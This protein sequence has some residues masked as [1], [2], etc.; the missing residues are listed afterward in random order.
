MNTAEKKLKIGVIGCGNIVKYAHMPAFL[1]MTDEAEVVALCD[2]KRERAEFY[3]RQCG[4]K[5]VFEDYGDLIALPEIDAVDICLPNYLHA[6][7][8]C[9]AFEAGKHVFCEKP[10]SISVRGVEDMKAAADKAGRVLMVMR[11][12]RFVPSS[13]YAKR[14]I[15]QG[16][17]GQIYAGHC[18]WQRRRGIPGLGG[19][20]TTKEMSGGGPLIDLGVHMIDLAVYL[21]GSPRP[22][23]VT[24]VT[25]RKF[26]D[27]KLADSDNA[28][29]GD[30]QENGVFDVEDLAM[31]FIRFENGACLTIEFSWASNIESERRFVQLY[32]DK[33]GLC[34]EDEQ[35]R[36]FGEE[37]GELVD[38]LPR[39]PKGIPGHEANLRHFARVVLHGEKPVYEPQ[40]GVDMV[41]ILTTMYESAQSGREV[42]L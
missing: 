32:G 30:A 5:Y 18:G 34:W 29:F 23:S 7:V 33:A 28:A 27:N 31:G 20:F 2:I 19:W 13:A 11:N 22:V 38:L 1:R 35:L 37:D 17:A 10:D 24:G 39:L 25:Y 15:T 4:A 40:Q 16:K 9:L 12:N 42:L 8:A 26:A 6:P 21:M 41:K 3:A 36:I 14:F